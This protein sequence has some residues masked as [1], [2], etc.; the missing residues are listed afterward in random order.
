MPATARPDAQTRAPRQRRAQERV[1][2]IL[3]AA[4]III[5]EKGSAGLTISEIAERAGVTPGSMYQYFE[6]KT[7]IIHRLGQLTLDEVH[8]R[9]ADAF[10]EPP[11]DL[12]AF[13]AAMADLFDGFW[14]LHR[15]DPVMRDIWAA[16]AADKTLQDLDRAD[17]ARNVALIY[18]K[19]RHLFAP[20]QRAEFRRALSLMLNFAATAART[21]IDEPEAEARK[22]KALSRTLIMA[23]WAD[24]LPRLKG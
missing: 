2:Q 14:M 22:I 18:D 17:T 4:R 21:A 13:K 8:G 19:S 10:A 12:E 6:N 1:D 11:A 15:T 7:A 24:L 9:I 3:E 23:G 16:A 5:G 20:R